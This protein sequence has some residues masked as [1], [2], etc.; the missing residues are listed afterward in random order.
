[1]SGRHEPDQ[2]EAE[3]RAAVARVQAGHRESFTELVHRHRS[4]VLRIAL[5]YVVDAGEAEDVTQQ[6]FVQALRALGGFRAES[7][8]ATW[9]HRIAV[10]TAISFTRSR[11]RAR[12][13]SLEE[14]ELITTALSTDRLAVR[15]TRRRL[16]EA[17]QELPPKQRLAVELRLVHELSFRDIA[18]ISGGSEG[19]AKSNFQHGVKKLRERLTGGSEG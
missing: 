10:N 17:L 12:E 5:R 2:S 6:T 13:V 16:A 4:A 7:S 8:F 9:L 19:S 18:A 11:G 3:D 15:Q 1:M 14:V